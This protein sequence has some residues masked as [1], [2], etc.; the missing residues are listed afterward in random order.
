MH[1]TPACVWPADGCAASGVGA[2]GAVAL[3]AE[4]HGRLAWLVGPLAATALCL[5]IASVQLA[6]VA[7]RER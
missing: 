7:A 2:A 5:L 3:F 4:I 6:V 1:L